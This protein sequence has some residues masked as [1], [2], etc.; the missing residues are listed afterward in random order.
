MNLN[1]SIAL[2]DA[3]KR[4]NGSTFISI[5]TETT[6][7]VSK[8]IPGVAPRTANPHFNAIQKIQT[9][10]SVMVFQN[11]RLNGYDSMVRRRLIKEDKNPDTFVLSPRTWGTRLENLPIVSHNGEYYLEVI[12]LRPGPTH[13]LYQ[14]QPI[15]RADIIG[16]KTTRPPHQGG[17]S[18]SVIIR[19]FAFSS[20][21]KIQINKKI[22]EFTT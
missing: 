18:N 22:I 10:S 20:L 5:D 6:L 11:K 4:V 2:F 16:M 13:Y 12:F 8:T 21:R 7:P 3:L 14:G 17:L 9:G 15:D 19:T 1:E